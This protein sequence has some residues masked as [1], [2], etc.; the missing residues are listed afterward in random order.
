[1]Q[2]KQSFISLQ[3]Y[4]V[5]EFLTLLAQFLLLINKNQA[6]V[7]MEDFNSIDYS[8][9]EEK[10]TFIFH[11]MLLQLRTQNGRGLHPLML[12][13]IKSLV[14]RDLI[15]KLFPCVNSSFVMFSCI[16]L[17]LE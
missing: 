11:I 2:S 6:L 7:L 8:S 12:H 14:Y 4:Q 3:K 13:V 10:T 9:K 5:L 1:M 15:I 17:L 16:I